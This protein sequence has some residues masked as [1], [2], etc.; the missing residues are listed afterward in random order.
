MLTDHGNDFRD[1]RLF[2]AGIIF[3]GTPHQ[4]SEAAVYDV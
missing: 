2:T 1:I 3:L 4:G